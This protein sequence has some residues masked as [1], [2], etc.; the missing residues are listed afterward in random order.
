MA[1]REEETV[2]ALVFTPEQM[3]GMIE[4]VVRA[5][6]E[7]GDEEKERIASEKKRKLNKRNAWMQEREAEEARRR[8]DYI[9]CKDNSRHRKDHPYEGQHTIQGQENGDGFV[10]A[11]CIKCQTE[12]PKFRKSVSPLM[13]QGYE[14]REMSGLTPGIIEQWA[15][16]SGVD[17]RP[18]RFE[19]VEAVA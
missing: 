12:F 10:H 15:K 7:P 6:K 18:Y 8:H 17:P 19:K 14:L 5:V 4:S 9:W 1:N 2:P 16:D 13:L 3:T 11:I